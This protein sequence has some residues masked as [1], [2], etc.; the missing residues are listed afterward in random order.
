MTKLYSASNRGFY[1][2]DVHG[3]AIPPDAVEIT[4][5][6]HASLLAAQSAGQVITADAA[7]RPIA[8]DLPPPTVEQQWQMLR[9]ERDRRLAASD[10]MV[11][12]DRWAAYDESQRAAWTAY[13]QALR[14]LPEQTADPAAPV[15]PVSPLQSA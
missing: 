11:L 2:R 3:D 5:D 10:V 4:D 1:C 9:A 14:D 15:W 8:V 6:E 13:R 7:G 12:P